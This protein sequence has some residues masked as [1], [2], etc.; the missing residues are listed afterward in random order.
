[1]CEISELKWFPHQ[2]FV[3]SVPQTPWGHHI[4]VVNL[5]F[6]RVRTCCL[7]SLKFEWEAQCVL[8]E[9]ELL[10]KV[11]NERVHTLVVFRTHPKCLSRAHGHTTRRWANLCPSHTVPPR[12]LSPHRSSALLSPLARSVRLSSRSSMCALSVTTRASLIVAE[13]L[14]LWL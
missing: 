6:S 3:I 10:L 1:M 5:L 9:G 4:L 14:V 7:C 2:I 8:N 13:C 12:W 11:A